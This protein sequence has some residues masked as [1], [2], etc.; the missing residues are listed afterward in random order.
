LRKVIYAL[1]RSSLVAAF[2]CSACFAQTSEISHT[3]K[4]LRRS[5]VDS[6]LPQSPREL[7]KRGKEL[8]FQ[9]H[10]DKALEVLEQVPSDAEL[11]ETDGEDLEKLLKATRKKATALPG[12]KGVTAR[13]QSPETGKGTPSRKAGATEGA[14]SPE[15]ALAAEARRLAD[16]PPVERKAGASKFLKI[17]RSAFNQGDIADAEQIAQTAVDIDAPFKA[18]EDSPEKLL[19]EIQEARKQDAT[20]KN[21]RS[22]PQAKRNRSNYLLRRAQQAARDGEMDIA[23]QFVADAEKLGATPGQLDL[24]PSDVRKQME[25]AGKTGGAG[26]RAASTANR[27]TARRNGQIQQIGFEDADATDA[28]AGSAEPV[29]TKVDGLVRQA[30]AAQRAGK[31]KEAL[32]AAQMAAKLEAA[33][34]LKYAPG[35]EKPSQYLASLMRKVPADPASLEIMEQEASEENAVVSENV[36]MARAL[37]AKAKQDIAK[38]DLESARSRLE[39]AADLKVPASEMSESPEELLASLDRPSAGKTSK[40]MGGAQPSAADKQKAKRLLAEAKTAFDSGDFVLARAKTLEAKKIDVTYDL[41]E[42]DPHQVEEQMDR[43]T[44][45]SKSISNKATQSVAAHSEEN[46]FAGETASRTEARTS[47][48]TGART[49][50][51]TGRR[52][53]GLP[54]S[55]QK[56]RALEL[57]ELARAE[58]KSGRIEDARRLANEAKEI[59]T[60][61]ALFDDRPEMVLADIEQAELAVDTTSQ[62]R[63]AQPAANSRAQV[64]SEGREPDLAKRQAVVMLRQARID[65]KAGRLKEAEEQALQAE[66][67]DAEYADFEDNPSLVLKEIEKAN[68]IVV[69]VRGETRENPYESD[70]T[71]HSSQKVVNADVISPDGDGSALGMYKE[72][73]LALARGDRAGAYHMFLQVSQSGEQLNPR[74][75]QQLEDFLQTLSPKGN[76]GR[77]EIRMAAHQIPTV[78]EAADNGDLESNMP[79]VGGDDQEMEQGTAKRARKPSQLDTVDQQLTIKLESL[80][81]QVMNTIFRADKLREKDPEGALKMLDKVQHELEISELSK[82]SV[83]PL[84]KSVARARDAAQATIQTQMANITQDKHNKEVGNLIKGDQIRAVKIEQEFADMTTQ[85]NELMQQ[86]RFPE[87]EIIAKKAKELDPSNP[88]AEI[89]VWK[90]KFGFRVDSNNKLRDSKEEGFWA[91]LDSVEHS[92]IPFDDRH[93]IQYGKNWSELSKKRAGKYGPDNRTRT[94]EEKRIE[95]SLSRQV[96]LHFDGEPLQN[97]IEQLATQSN[98]NIRLDPQGLEEQQVNTDT[99][100]TIN[101]DGIQMRSALNLILEPLQLGYTIKDEV[102]KITSVERQKGA[103][104]SRVYPVA[105]L[106]IPIPNFVNSAPMGGYNGSSPFLSNAG[107]AQYNIPANRPSGQAF[108]QVQDGQPG[109]VGGA[110]GTGPRDR[111]NM[112]P[113]RQTATPDFDSLVDLIVGTVE[114]T[115]WD[116]VGGHATVKPF[117]TTLSL[118]IRQTQQ[119]HDEIQ[120]LLAQL[121]RLQ[122]LQVSIEV[123]FVTVSDKFF[124]RIGI[125]FDFNVKGTAPVAPSPQ[126]FGDFLPPFGNGVNFTGGTTTSGQ[127]TSGQTT[128]GSTTSGTTTSGVAGTGSAPFAPGPA[129]D[130]VRRGDYPKLGTIVGLEAPNTFSNDLQIP[131]RQGSFDIGVPDF[132]G[133]KPDAGLSM[134]FAILSDIETFFFIQ[135]AQGDSRTNILFAPKVTL[136]NGQQATVEDTLNRPFVIGQTPVVG[137]FTVAFTPNIQ[138]FSEGVHLRVNAVISADRRYVRLS[139]VPDFRSITDVFTFSFSGSAGAAGGGSN[140]ATG[141]SGS[142]SNI[143]GG[144]GSGT[145]SGGSGGG[146]SGGGSGTT[147][148]GTSTGGTTSG[149]TTSGGTTSGQQNGGSLLQQPATQVVQQPVQEVISIQTS[150]SV[151]DGGTVLL[152]GIKRL[153]EGRNMQGVPILNKLPYISR[154]FKNSGVGRETDSLMMMVTPRIIIQEEEEAEVMGTAP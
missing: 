56:Q 115:T 107:G 3:G 95:K 60:V 32:Q 6:Q 120:D 63:A 117:E 116:E 49:G 98:I 47:A 24:K 97:V 26:Q 36:E 143:G 73:K 37:V 14:A 88:T 1:A 40:N 94:D 105:D 8:Y 46:Q 127:T 83:T 150:V 39:H 101:V 27:T 92:A 38:G 33:S 113:M 149:G 137:A 17:A 82:A 119:A 93:P 153:K 111:M 139:L 7:L 64:A 10:Y 30:K 89:M 152:G 15:A 21:D 91:A 43:S 103:M 54:L 125:D 58:L 104:E 61:Y 23:K 81:T 134:G 90:A 68:G 145:S 22:S 34:G 75:K 18:N 133:Y 100:I 52:T 66:K 146:T 13:A 122:D 31:M 114:P 129:R 123:R 108:A 106:V 55:G 62:R 110:A 80:R 148:G 138:V 130:L 79:T 144:G 19:A 135:A 128:S 154:L 35:E 147:S 142:G 72:G 118:V 78:G 59:N 70:P 136:F 126:S 85:F 124:E 48:R 16:L 74:V 11:S 69:A 132:G 71:L 151:P 87:A 12:R 96:S 102:L 9:G 41:F 140:Q 65:L 131:F 76:R 53:S 45:G 121:R 50:G 51:R 112:D 25:M 57:L 29:R 67:M 2:C 86:R 28:D 84:L 99:K 109:A 4:T 20:W 5:G 42:A 44:A 77:D 141:F